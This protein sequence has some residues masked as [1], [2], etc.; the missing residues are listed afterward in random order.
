MGYETAEELGSFVY[1]ADLLC[2][3]E[4]GAGTTSKIERDH[5]R[6][7]GVLAESSHSP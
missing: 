4:N 5:N 7:E 3:F 1:L 2:L 6:F